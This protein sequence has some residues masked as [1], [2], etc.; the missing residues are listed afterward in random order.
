ME[1]QT[2]NYSS[3]E[4]KKRKNRLYFTFIYLVVIFALISVFSAMVNSASKEDII[5]STVIAAFILTIIVI[6]TYRKQFKIINGFKKIYLTIDEERV[7]IFNGLLTITMVIKN[8]KNIDVKTSKKGK[9][10]FIHLQSEPNHMYISGFEKIDEILDL[11]K[12]KINSTVNI[13]YKK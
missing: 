5:I 12:N 11:I 3:E 9:I 10:K 13:N 7:E 4:I 2:F 6:I 8:I 1:I